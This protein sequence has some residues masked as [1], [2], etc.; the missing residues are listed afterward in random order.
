MKSKLFKK[1]SAIALAMCMVLSASAVALAGWEDDVYTP[2]FND[3]LSVLDWDTTYG[4]DGFI[5][6]GDGTNG[7]VIYSDL[8]QDSA[9][10][11][12]ASG[13]AIASTKGTSY[14]VQGG[15]GMDTY[16]HYKGTYYTF[17]Q[18]ADTVLPIVQANGGT[19]LTGN[20][21]DINSAIWKDAV[22][23]ADVL[24][25][26]GEGG[27]R[28]D[29]PITKWLV[30]GSTWA[31]ATGFSKWKTPAG[32]IINTRV[33]AG[34]KSYP[35]T[36]AFQLTA[37]AVAE[38]GIYV[39]VHTYNMTGGDMRLVK[40]IFYHNNAGAIADS[41]QILD[42]VDVPGSGYTTFYI[43]TA[44]DYT[45][46]AND[47]NTQEGI[48]GMF[49]DKSEPVAYE[50]GGYSST[51]TAASSEW[52]GYFGNDGY[53]I[54]AHDGTTQGA[55]I[56]GL[57]DGVDGTVITACA[58][59]NILSTSNWN[60]PLAGMSY[61]SATWV[62]NASTMKFAP[63]A[64]GTTTKVLG[65]VHGNGKVSTNDTTSEQGGA[66]NFAITEA[67]LDR[68]EAV[69][70]ERA[71]YV[72]VLDS[73]WNSVPAGGAFTTKLY[74][75]TVA[76]GITNNGLASYSTYTDPTSVNYYH[77][78]TLRETRVDTLS[79]TE[80]LYVTFKLTAEGY[81]GITSRRD[82]EVS[83]T[84]ENTQGGIQAVFTDYVNP[85]DNFEANI[86]VDLAGGSLAEGDSIPATYNPLTI[87]SGI[88]LPTPVKAG[89]TFAGWKVN[90]AD[91]VASYTI[92]SANIGD[93]SLVATWLGVDEFVK[94]DTLNVSDWEGTY[95][96][97]GYVIL[98]NTANSF[99]SDMYTDHTGTEV[100]TGTRNYGWVYKSGTNT[101]I[102]AD[103]PIS[104]WGYTG[105]TWSSTSNDTTLYIPGTTTK[106]N[107]RIHNSGN[108]P[109][110]VAMMVTTS[111]TDPV[112][113]TVYL[114]KAFSTDA[115]K[116]ESYYSEEYPV[117]LALY[118]CVKTG[119]ICA[120]NP[121][122][123]NLVASYQITDNTGVYVTFLLRNARDYMISIEGVNTQTIKGMFGGIFFDYN[124]PEKAKTLTVDKADGSEP[125]ITEFKSYSSDITLE[126]PTRFGYTFAGW[127]VDGAD[128]VPEFTLDCSEATGNVS[129]V[130]TWTPI[131]YNI[132]VNL[133]G[134]EANIP[135][136]YTIES[137]DIVLP[138]PVRAGFDFAG[139]KV[140]GA[141]AVM[142]YTIA[143]GSTG[144]ISL[145]ATWTVH[146]NTITYVVGE[147]GTLAST[148]QLIEVGE[149]YALYIPTVNN[150]S[151]TFAG[152]KVEGTDEIITTTGI[153]SINGD[154]TLVAV[155]DDVQLVVGADNTTQSN[156]QGLYG[157]AGYIM[158][159]NSSA[160]DKAIYSS[161]IYDGDGQNVK[162]AVTYSVVEGTTNE[163]M[164]REVFVG[165]ATA[166]GNLIS[167]FGIQAQ[168]VRGD[169]SSAYSGMHI[170]GTTTVSR[171]MARSGEA[172]L[173]LAV[174]FYLT[175]AAL[176]S[177]YLATGERAIYVTTYA[178][179]TANSRNSGESITANLFYSNSEDITKLAPNANKAGSTC[180]T[181]AGILD[182]SKKVA[183]QV[184]NFN[185]GDYAGVYFTFKLTAAGYYGI[186]T[187]D[188]NQHGSWQGLF[189]DYAAPE[190]AKTLTVDKANGSEIENINFFSY[191]EDIPLDAPS[192]VGY[193]FAGWSVDGA[194]AVLEYTLDCSEATGDVYV[195]ATWTPVAYNIN[196]NLNG[197]EANIP[198]TYTIESADIVLPTPVRAG[199]DFAG[200]KVN[201]ADAVMEYTIASGSTGDIS[202]EATWTVHKNTITYVVGEYGTLAST[203][204]LIEV[205][206]TYALYIPTIT[207]IT[208]S[209]AGWKVE[210]SEEI[211]ATTGVWNIE[212]DV[213]LVAVYNDVQLAVGT[214]GTTQANWEGAY[215]N[216][217]Y[218]IYA[219]DSTTNRFIYHK[220]IYAGYDESTYSQLSPF[221]KSTTDATQEAMH[222]DFRVN[223]LDPDG[224]IISTFGDQTYGVKDDTT[225]GAGLYKPGTLGINKYRTRS[226]NAGA[227]AQ[228]AVAFYVPADALTR[229]TTGTIYVSMYVPGEAAARN[230]GDSVTAS[231]FYSN[232]D[233]LD[234]LLA[235][236][237]HDDIHGSTTNSGVGILNTK[238][239]VVSQTHTY[240]EGDANGV[241]LTFAIKQA[242][243]YAVQAT[244]SEERVGWSGIFF[245]YE[246]PVAN[247]LSISYVSTVK[248][249]DADFDADRVNRYGE[250]YY[251]IAA[252]A[253][254]TDS[255]RKTG[256]VD[257]NMF[258]DDAYVD[259]LVPVKG[260]SSVGGSAGL[261]QP[262]TGAY[263]TDIPVRNI[264]TNTYIRD[265]T[266]PYGV[267]RSD[268]ETKSNALFKGNG[269]AAGSTSLPGITFEVYTNE[270]IY[271]TAYFAQEKEYLE[272]G[273]PYTFDIDVN[274]YKNT[275]FFDSAAS[276]IKG[277]S[278]FPNVAT[279]M[280]TVEVSEMNGAY[281]TF[282]ISGK[283]IYFLAA[284]FAQYVAGGNLQVAPQ[285]L[286]VSTSK[287]VAKNTITVDLAGGEATLDLPKYF[288][289]TTADITLP[290]PVKAGYDFAGWSVNGAPAVME[291]TLDCSEA[292]GSVEA[293]ATWTAKEYGITIDLAGGD[294]VDYVAP[295]TYTVEYSDI[296]IPTPEKVHYDF[297]GWLVN[298]AETP[299]ANYVITTGSTG[300]V[301]L[302][303]VW[304]AATYTIT[305]DANGGDI[306]PTTQSVVYGEAYSLLIPTHSD[307]TKVFGGWQIVD[308]D[309]IASTGFWA[310][311]DV[312]LVAIWNKL[313]IEVKTDTTT[314]S[315]SDW[316][317]V[318]GKDGYLVTV[319]NEN[320]AKT[321][322]SDLYVDEV[323]TAGTLGTTIESTKGTTNKV[324]GGIINGV[325]EFSHYTGEFYTLAQADLLWDFIEAMAD[326]YSYTGTLTHDVNRFAAG[327]F[328]EPAEGGVANVSI[329]GGV[330]YL[331]NTLN[332]NKTNTALVV[333][334]KTFDVTKILASLREDYFADSSPISRFSVSGSTWKTSSTP[335][336]KLEDGSTVGADIRNPDVGYPYTIS[337][338]VK[339]SA[340]TNGPIYVTSYVSNVSAEATVKLRSGFITT[341]P[342]SDAA[343]DNYPLLGATTIK[344]NGFVTFE[345][346]TPG[347]YIFEAYESGQRTGL[348][349]LFFDRD[350]Y[351]IGHTIVSTDVGDPNA[352]AYY[353][354]DAWL[355][356]ANTVSDNKLG[357][358]MVSSGIIKDKATGE[359]VD[360]EKIDLLS[361]DTGNN[362]IAFGLAD[363]E[364][365][366]FDGIITRLGA[367]AN[368]MRGQDNADWYPIHPDGSNVAAQI[369]GGGATQNGGFAFT[370]DAD[371]F[372]GHDAIYV[373]VADTLNWTDKPTTSYT[374]NVQLYQGYYLA[375][376]TYNTY[377]SSAVKMI[378]SEAIEGVENNQAV[379]VTFKITAPGTY[380]INAIT[381][382]DRP[383]MSAIYFDYDM[384]NLEETRNVVV[385]ADNATVNAP[386]FI[387]VGE[388]A[389]TITVA[390]NAGYK[391]STIT[392]AGV[393]VE[394]TDMVA[395]TVELPVV[396]A[397]LKGALDVVV[398]TEEVTVAEVVDY[399][400]VDGTLY[401]TANTL[402]VA[403]EFG[404]E[405]NGVKYAA[406]KTKGE[407]FYTSIDGVGAGENT[408]RPYMVI[409]GSTLY[410]ANITETLVESDGKTHTPDVFGDVFFGD[411]TDAEE[412]THENTL[413]IIG[414]IKGVA[415]GSAEIVEVG[416]TF[417]LWN[418]TTKVIT[419]AL[420]VDQDKLADYTISD[421]NF[422]FAILNMDTAYSVNSFKVFIKYA[423]DTVVESVAYDIDWVDGTYVISLAD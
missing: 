73:H 387:T 70:G 256:A 228:T 242:G 225:A 12:D 393:E 57:V 16:N 61:S 339:E 413:F 276:N 373:T 152:W 230:A 74:Y 350:L 316:Y 145:E 148:T 104:R 306:S 245:D 100:I 344:A 183:S 203:T 89:Y 204:Q 374:Y 257:S 297:V 125:T 54:A 171:V 115:S 396:R 247:A 167:H 155:Y 5:L 170:P 154:V 79:T 304:T 309:K 280:Q 269:N 383:S 327:T 26:T 376:G 323:Y 270:T 134:G 222:R 401:V 361:T 107:A 259:G 28:P 162:T 331:R 111:T 10:A 121:G 265:I 267:L 128:A 229:S 41:V 144:D 42:R 262:L 386:E 261:I 46:V 80:A 418:G 378:A 347:N 98:A 254:E 366:A 140:N 384:P 105:G 232:S 318:Y 370:L 175:D 51:Y 295:E 235:V 106:T 217:G 298:G 18:V 186:Q 127:S 290:T 307:V 246:K 15:I 38:G 78:N 52:E 75:S 371:A 36:I 56:G 281:V 166:N 174:S 321:V 212:G 422:G 325:H 360:G 423:D 395:M 340:L 362:T 283:G 135:A 82:V 84:N 220:G 381:G 239:K 333:G 60:G 169:T 417:S 249:G 153:W 193:T 412:V 301:S 302:V 218:I 293:V 349:G 48:T 62:S 147:Y 332:N 109:W 34:D 173:Q 126:A 68:A 31:G 231:L 120:T 164:N 385:S 3:E 248:Y 8:Y 311:E 367:I 317:K 240:A 118:N 243:Y 289:E 198:A 33:Q 159:A 39:T 187:L 141:D 334:D 137:A 1:V 409:G 355:Y 372:V 410:G 133:N 251:F 328:T 69:T 65:R 398:T 405:M 390:A 216:A 184:Y 277:N 337:F 138:T 208:K 300:D 192:R 296:V 11:T 314:Y 268:G 194:E 213:T 219:G 165:G 114:P 131:A 287:P 122:Y 238:K 411:Y 146:K 320:N 116:P 88:V 6:L 85:V 365:Y 348:Q 196:V 58:N 414:E 179:G 157:S 7:A 32:D 351:D 286:Y 205:G 95:G 211:I 4:K 103:A 236:S 369:G 87:E 59:G 292:T 359:M 299:V 97:D 271:V 305:Y 191:S 252:T 391:L 345:I 326:L 110:S 99:Y 150:I 210:G 77:A 209:F 363:A 123:T 416:V 200:W 356:V 282:A 130:A 177:A 93:L 279:L 223:S 17:A 176:E 117:T 96:N 415:F 273:T 112:Y 180:N 335:N 182:A 214:D 310:M 403:D 27:L 40:N 308:G 119:Q 92:T 49:F 163:S 303:A 142:E 221:D 291:Y 312:S 71:I 375:L 168:L 260:A 336:W 156:W 420:D 102:K 185:D 397:S 322:Y 13:N 172:G 380:T 113:M 129:V 161:N 237:T 400:L 224:T 50:I 2:T 285:A 86:N 255:N 90:G 35:Y 20:S 63:Y 44:G 215:G 64:P 132:N 158:Y 9:Y 21:S 202:L 201:G 227:S 319:G 22:A 94:D 181:Q 233:N 324:Y 263:R 368:N 37:D 234:T 55:Y 143:S 108:A 352:Y 25:S 389:Q 199:F 178:P 354:A 14:K 407:T 392:V 408:F 244:D 357:G 315:L 338:T 151:K 419:Q 342:T 346:K 258:T 195:V 421:K 343:L 394:I 284:E 19:S 207:N 188:A 382:V 406:V 76:T 313:E 72:T 45:I 377:T 278:N 379:Y 253:D 226:S 43:E 353:G 81:Y 402:A 266:S 189:F 197:G 272:D 341:A 399:L 23:K 358:Y 275:Y 294:F 136:T 83:A 206:E 67:N 149:T 388:A 66:V 47:P 404:I 274:L 160:S 24:N 101:G 250:E 91:A 364:T 53:F 190:R 329:S 139:W 30:S 288:D 264:Y 330:L 124:I 29:A 241:Y